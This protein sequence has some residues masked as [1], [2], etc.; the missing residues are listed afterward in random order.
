MI[1]IEID[2]AKEISMLCIIVLSSLQI[3]VLKSATDMKLITT[4]KTNTKKLRGKE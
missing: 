2:Y 4:I 3:I 1:Y